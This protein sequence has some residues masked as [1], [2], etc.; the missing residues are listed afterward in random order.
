MT[1]NHQMQLYQIGTNLCVSGESCFF[2]DVDKTTL[3]LGD[4]HDTN[5]CFGLNFV[6][7]H[8][9]TDETGTTYTVGS[10]FIT[11]LKYNFV[12]IPPFTGKPTT[13]EM[14]KTSEII[15]SISSQVS[16]LLS[17]HHSFGMTS[18]YLVCACCMSYYIWHA[19]TKY[20]NIK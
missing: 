18:N 20:H 12:K 9:L 13:K 3:Q 7:P 11:G 14:L 10:S 19:E 16:T 8:L 2:R 1:D 4:K 5:K 6:S 15:A 17:M